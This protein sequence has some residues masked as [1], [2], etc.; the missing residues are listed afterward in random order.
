MIDL[1]TVR[2]GA[3][4]RIPFS[5]FDK[6]DGS[7]ITMTNFAVGDILV[8]KDGSTTERAS[9][10]GETATTDFD[11]KTGKHFAI[12]DLA[13]NTTAGFYAA[14]SEYHV[15]IDAVTVDGVTV[16]GWVAR[17]RIGYRN[18]VHDTTIATLSSQTSFTL[19]AGPAEDDALNG[20]WC[21]IHD[22]A[23]AVQWSWAL[24]A[25]YTGSTK[26]VTL[27]AGATFTVAAADNISIMG[28]DAIGYPV[29]ANGLAVDLS[30]VAGNVANTVSALGTL[31]DAA[32]DGAV[33][34][35]DTVVAYL[36]QLINT[37]EGG[38]GIVT[39][40]AAASAGH[41]VS[42]AEV[43][44]AIAERLG[45]PAD[46]GGGASVANNL[47]DVNNKI[48]TVD[49]FLDTEIAAILA[50]VDTEVAALV[51]ATYV[52]TGTAQAGAGTTITLDAGASAVDDFYNK[53]LIVITAGTGAG[54][55][56]FIDD[57]V[58][59]TKVATVA[60]WATNPSSDSVFYILPF[61]AIAGATA[62]TAAE[63]ADAVWAEAL[64]GSYGSG[65]AGKIIGDNLN[66]TVSSR[67][68]QTSLDTVSGNV[69]DIEFHTSQLHDVLVPAI[70][71][72]VDA[73][74]AKTDAL[75]SDPADA[76][77]VAAGIAGLD[78]KLDTI[79]NFLDTEIAAILEDT[80]TT[81]DDLVDDLE[82]R[83]TAALAAKLTAHAAGVLVMVVDAGS[84]T[85][86]VVFK[87]VEGVAASATNDQY[88]GRVI[89]F[90]SGTL[91]G[92]ATSID[93][94]VGAT[95]T[96]TVPALTGAPAENVTAVIV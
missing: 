63:V 86:A 10:A 11:S 15:A 48:D 93:D 57:Y 70:D 9:D 69:D 90:T 42:L 64:P 50:A 4:I 5:S 25:D 80:G 71:T 49:N 59:A 43:I 27:I 60:T 84:S 29:S 38:P 88:N 8:Y 54:Q 72:V 89:I 3:T 6:D 85:T 20:M 23:S 12:I 77:D 76:S 37:L 35:T 96:A 16:G 21:V 62:P 92:Q 67:A 73:I 61:G 75:P 94:Y 55:S 45:V 81:L 74:K 26:T 91:A 52:R 19:T 68:S 83:L 33:T 31:N 41:G 46:L 39:F 30:N 24:I 17:F 1:G 51:A 53:T 13:D 56:R 22:V 47:S 58:G 40:P 87:T 2:P 79:D 14:G 95:K 28:R 78:A 7:S 34:T 44:R 65:E 82:S 36:K 66:A 18:A 32:A